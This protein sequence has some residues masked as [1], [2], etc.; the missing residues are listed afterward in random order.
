MEIAVFPLVPPVILGGDED[1]PYNSAWVQ[2]S[3][4]FVSLCITL[5]RYVFLWCPNSPNSTIFLPLTILKKYEIQINHFVFFL[6]TQNTK[7]STI[8]T[9]FM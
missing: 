8:F 5:F 3:V 6:C 7:N 4:R 1:P 2:V 9:L